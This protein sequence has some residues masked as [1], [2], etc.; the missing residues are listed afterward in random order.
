MPDMGN[1]EDIVW[2]FLDNP[3]DNPQALITAADDDIDFVKTCSL[4]LANNISLE[5]FY[6]AALAE[7]IDPDSIVDMA[8]FAAGSKALKEVMHLR[9][10][11]QQ[12]A[13]MIKPL[14][15]FNHINE[16]L[17]EKAAATIKAQAEKFEKLN[18]C[19]KT[20]ALWTV[21]KA[22]MVS[23]TSN[24]EQDVDLAVGVLN[25]LNDYDHTKDLIEMPMEPGAGNQGAMQES[26]PI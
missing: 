14:I 5:D 2:G 13:E 24:N 12:L 23:M 1:F 20:I 25:A 18:K 4:Y 6:N 10:L 17:L 22:T 21:Q 11:N 19:Y 3:D 9:V 16:S 7:P 26:V 8:A 15:Q